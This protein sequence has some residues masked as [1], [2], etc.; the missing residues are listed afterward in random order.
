MK[1]ISLAVL[2][3]IALNQHLVSAVAP[4]LPKLVDKIELRYPGL[5][6]F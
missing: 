6:N 1:A 2:V 3:I 5:K 4:Y